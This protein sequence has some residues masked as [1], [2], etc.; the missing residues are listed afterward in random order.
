VEDKDNFSKF[1]E[2]FGKESQARY[3]Q[4]CSKLAKF[5]RFFSIKLVDEQVSLKGEF[6]LSHHDGI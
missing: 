2:A 1:Y 4:N 3:P 6:F 5:L